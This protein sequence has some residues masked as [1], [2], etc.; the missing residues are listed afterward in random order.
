MDIK[1]NHSAGIIE[2]KL[3]CGCIQHYQLLK[4]WACDR[5]AKEAADG[6]VALFG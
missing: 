1:I 3:E 5:H 4:T 6:L 2:V